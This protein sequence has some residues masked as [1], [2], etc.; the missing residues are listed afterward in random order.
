VSKS[1]GTLAKPV[2]CRIEAALTA[3]ARPSRPA[4][5]TEYLSTDLNSFTIFTKD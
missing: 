4:D 3:A 2:D 1:T 5:S